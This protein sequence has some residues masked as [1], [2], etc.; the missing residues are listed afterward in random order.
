MGLPNSGRRI[1]E[2]KAALRATWGL[3][4]FGLESIDS[5]RTRE[6]WQGSTPSASS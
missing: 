5:T 2:L 4:I 6:S 1:G 3:K